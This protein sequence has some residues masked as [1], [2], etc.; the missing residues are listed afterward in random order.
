[1]IHEFE[2]VEVEVRN[3]T[4]ERLSRTAS[5]KGHDP[6]RIDTVTRH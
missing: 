1:M 6:P 5:C 4:V 2:D 3:V